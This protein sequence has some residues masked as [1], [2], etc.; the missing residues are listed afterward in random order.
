MFAS[1]REFLDVSCV[2]FMLQR[3]NAV[4]ANRYQKTTTH[5]NK[6][7]KAATKPTPNIF[8]KHRK[9]N[10]KQN[11][12]TKQLPHKAF[13]SGKPLPINTTQMT[14]KRNRRA[15]RR[16]QTTTTQ[17]NQKLSTTT[18]QNTMQSNQKLKAATKPAPSQIQ[19][20]KLN[21]ANK[22]QTTA[23]QFQS[24]SKSEHS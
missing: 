22:Y 13:Q 19:H 21:T 11:N 23:K 20:Q 17:R 12:T 1:A 24:K 15:E 4:A 6:D 14:T 8:Q 9:R 18:K 2:C 7:M 5:S 16:Y 3:L 10:K